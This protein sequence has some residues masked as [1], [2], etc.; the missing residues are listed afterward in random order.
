MMVVIVVSMPV[1]TI[2][3]VMI[4]VTTMSITIAIVAVPATVV[5]AVMPVGIATSILRGTPSVVC[6][7]ARASARQCQRK[8]R[9]E[10]RDQKRT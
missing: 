9:P 8:Y 7:R 5:V 4:S 6:P 10:D 3:P 2:V 1:V